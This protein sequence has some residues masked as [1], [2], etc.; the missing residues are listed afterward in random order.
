[1]MQRN[2]DRQQ[3]DADQHQADRAERKN[4]RSG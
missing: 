4:A 1:M 2:R 3:A